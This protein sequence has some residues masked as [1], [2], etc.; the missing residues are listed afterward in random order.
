MPETSAVN[1]SFLTQHERQTDGH[2]YVAHFI[3]ASRWVGIAL[4]T[5]GFGAQRS[6]MSC[7]MKIHSLLMIRDSHQGL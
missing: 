2:R 5:T 6:E 4:M 7:E 1:E 3:M